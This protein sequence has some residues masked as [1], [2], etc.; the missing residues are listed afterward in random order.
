MSSQLQRYYVFLIVVILISLSAGA[1]G[2]YYTVTYLAAQNQEK[3]TKLGGNNS[4]TKT[5]ADT[6]KIPSRP[7]A[8]VRTAIATRE[9][10]STIRAFHGRLA[11]ISRAT[12]SSEVSGKIMA[13]PIEPG[14]SVLRGET[15][16]AQIDTTWLEIARQQTE[17][18]IAAMEA[19]LE[20]H[21]R[22]LARYEVIAQRAAISESELSLQKT[23]VEERRQNLIRMRLAHNEI[24]ERLERTKIFAPFN[25]YVTRRHSQLGELVSSGAPLAEI[26]SE[27]EI[28]AI[29]YIPE[30]FI[31]RAREGN[32]LPVLIDSLG[33]KVEGRIHKIVPD[34]STAAR[35]FPIY[36]RIS[37]RN[38]ALKVGM[39]ATAFLSI[40]DE[41]DGIVVPRDAV[42]E[43]PDGNTVWVVEQETTESDAIN[44][45]AVSFCVQSV[46]VSLTAITNE[47]YQVSAETDAG[48][49]LLTE[50]ALVVIEGAER[51]MP[52]QTVRLGIDPPVQPKIGSGHTIIAPP[53]EPLTIPITQ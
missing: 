46:P 42:L 28:D 22:D 20:H 37:D 39:S 48:K 4:A 14:S 2:M 52:R 35:V 3:L 9:T 15:L 44:S 49:K 7:P 10:L 40:S 41:C 21:S 19:Q 33:I 51:L 43:K 29:V 53:K 6:S 25:G 47:K 12:I 50:G 23:N 13:I 31:T 5:P 26:I 45:G 11:E 34:A 24:L 36:I 27:G 38:G 32:I 30:N 17:A 1:A 18:E 16:I 8:L